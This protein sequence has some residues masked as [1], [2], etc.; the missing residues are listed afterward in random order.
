MKRSECHPPAS[1]LPGSK[2]KRGNEDK[3]LTV[4]SVA[5]VNQRLS[6]PHQ[7]SEDSKKHLK[8]KTIQEHLLEVNEKNCLL[9]K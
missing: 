5:T 6:S 2:G 4:G 9:I 8:K 7:E 1:F 3:T